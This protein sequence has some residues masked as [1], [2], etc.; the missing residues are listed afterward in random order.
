VPLFCFGVGVIRALFGAKLLGLCANSL[1][2]PL[3]TVAGLIEIP[4]ISCGFDVPHL[5]APVAV[6]PEF[7]TVFRKLFRITEKSGG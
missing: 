7:C 4:L 1:L 2:S 5:G 6:C 3:L